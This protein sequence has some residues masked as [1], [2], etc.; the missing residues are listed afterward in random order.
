MDFKKLKFLIKS[1]CFRYS[2]KMTRYALIRTYL[3]H[4]GFKYSVWMRARIYFRQ[5]KIF[6]YGVYHISKWMQRRLMY[7]YGI[8][9]P[10]NPNIGSGLY[11]GHFG[12]IFLTAGAKIGKNLNISQQVT[13]GQDSR[14]R[15][16]G[17]PTIGDNVYIGSGAKIFGNIKIGNNVAIGANCVVTKDVPDNGVVVGI[18]GKVISD[19]GSYGYINKTEYE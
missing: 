1:D 18:P 19:K 14:G 17:Y 13:V 10:L 11:I 12:G 9:I 16:K 8:R 5:N 7:K 6:R 15:N 4:P 2:G 3:R